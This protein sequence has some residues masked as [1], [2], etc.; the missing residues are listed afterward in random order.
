MAQVGDTITYTFSDGT[1]VAEDVSNVEEADIVY[2]EGGG[3]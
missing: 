2:C 1:S 3:D